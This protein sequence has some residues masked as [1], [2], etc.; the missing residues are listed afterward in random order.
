[1]ASKKSK[2][3]VNRKFLT[4]L[5]N[6]IYNPDTGRF[7]RLCDGTLQNGPDPTDEKRPMHC[8]L[9]ELYF[10]M[11]GRQP[12][13]QDHVS[14]HDVIDEAVK[15]SC[16]NDGGERA[17]NEA[18]ETIQAL[19]IPGIV[20][21][22]LI[23]TLEM[24]YENARSDRDDETG[25]HRFMP[26]PERKFRETLNMIPEKNDDGCGNDSCSYDTFR[27]RARR[28]ATQLRKAAKFLP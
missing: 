17:L 10:A 7:L 23:G 9:G 6:S 19:A 4:D 1:M 18:R 24:G 25:T 22:E 15:R 5:A 3:V 11:T 26:E 14:E 21:E 12:R 20:K 2:Q 13:S 27:G 16:L 28:V 8:G